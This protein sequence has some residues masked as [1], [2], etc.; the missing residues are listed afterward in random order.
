MPGEGSFHLSTA[1]CPA[2]RRKRVDEIRSKLDNGETCR[3]VSTSIVEC[4]M[5]L[6]FPVVYRALAG[7]DSVVQAGG[8]CNREGKRPLADSVVKVFESERA[9][10][11]MLGQNISAARYAMSRY[12]DPA[13]PEA[14][15][16][17]FHELYYGEKGMN[18]LDAAG[19]LGLCGSGD[20]PFKETAESFHIIDDSQY[21]VYIPKPENTE[22]IY[23]LEHSGPDRELMRSL[24]QYAVGAYP[25]YYK[26]L[27]AALIPIPGMNGASILGDMRLYSDETGL[28]MNAERGGAAF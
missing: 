10:P 1:M 19:I 14:V 5:D 9:A 21:T 13:S 23:K 16:S 25:Q 4:G 8:R 24:G 26:A 3:V 22:L 7:L 6:D 12:P 18:A 11:R 17:Y 20:F 27:G 15:S 2:D 28:V